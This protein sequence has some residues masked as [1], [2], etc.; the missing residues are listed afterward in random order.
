MQAMQDVPWLPLGS[1]M[2]PA[3]WKAN[4]TGWVKGLVQYTGVKRG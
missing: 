4:L 3:A 2:Q 1:Y